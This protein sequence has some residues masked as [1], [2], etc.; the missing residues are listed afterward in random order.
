[1]RSLVDLAAVAPL[2]TTARALDCARYERLVT[3]VGVRRVLERVARKGR[4]GVKIMRQLLDERVDLPSPASAMSF[5]FASLVRQFTLPEP[6]P[7]CDVYDDDG[8]WLARVDFA[9]PYAKLFIELDGLETHGSGPALQRDLT[10]QNG[11]VG[12]GW[13]PLRY[14]WADLSRRGTEVAAEVRRVRRQRLRLL[15]VVTHHEGA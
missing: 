9:Y 4:R 10:R 8:H 7:E 13:Q 3:L 5:K 15:G 1:M 12:A 2:G 6:I 11:L 14:T